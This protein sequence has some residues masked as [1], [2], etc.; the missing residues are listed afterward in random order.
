MQ[1]ADEIPHKFF[2]VIYLSV[3]SYSIVLMQD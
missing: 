3:C 1:A 2:V